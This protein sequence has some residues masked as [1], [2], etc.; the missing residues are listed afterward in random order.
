YYVN[1][2]GS[3]SEFPTSNL[4]SPRLSFA[5]DVFGNGKLALKGSWGRYI[6]ITS[7]PNSQPGVGGNNPIATTSCTYNWDGSIPFDAKKNAGPDG[8]ILTSDDLNLT[9]SSCGKT[10]ILNGQVVPTA[11]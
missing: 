11:T 10:A 4:I 6:G 1:A 2:D 7:S 9:S 8:V 3:K 5:Y